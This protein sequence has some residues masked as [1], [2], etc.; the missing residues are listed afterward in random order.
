MPHTSKKYEIIESLNKNTK[1]LIWNMLSFGDTFLDHMEPINLIADYFGE[2][3][4][5]YL[6]FMFHH[7]GWLILPGTLGTILFL[8]HLSLGIKHRTEDITILESYSKEVDSVMNYGY[9]VLITLWAT[10]YIESWKRK[11]ATLSY[12]WGLEERKDQI[13][14]SVKLTQSNTEY[15]FNSQKGKKE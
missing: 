7:L 5:L 3:Y 2:K 1:S 6:A 14:R 13:E 4:A 12:I 10:F 8:M 11:H 15:I 9:I